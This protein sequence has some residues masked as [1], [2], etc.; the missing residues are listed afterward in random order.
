MEPER[1]VSLAVQI[2]ESIIEKS[3]FSFFIQV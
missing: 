1:V 2:G 3:G